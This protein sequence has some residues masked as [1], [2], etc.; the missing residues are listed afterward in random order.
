MVNNLKRLKVAAIAHNDEAKVLG[1][2]HASYPAAD[3]NFFVQIRLSGTVISLTVV[4]FISVNS[5][6]CKINFLMRTAL[7]CADRV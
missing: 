4:K 5:L 3:L 1:T 2:A 6:F 7:Q